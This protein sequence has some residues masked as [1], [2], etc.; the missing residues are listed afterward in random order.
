MLSFHLQ[1]FLDT[2]YETSPRQLTFNAKT[3]DEVAHWQARLRTALKAQLR[4][5]DRQLPGRI[6]A[7]ELY[8]IERD[9]YTETKLSLGGGETPILVYVL[10]PKTPPPYKA[11]MAFPGHGVGVELIL[12]LQSGSNLESDNDYAPGFA[13]AGYLV[14]AV[15]QQGFGER[16]TDQVA[17]TGAPT[18]C[19]HLAFEYLMHDRTLLGERVWDGMLAVQYI[20][21]RADVDPASIGCVGHSGGGT[22]TLFL[23]ALDERIGVSVI[24]CYFCSFRQSILKVKHC[25]CNYVPGLLKLAENGDFA[26]LIAPQPV[27]FI[28]GEKD[29][30]FDING[31]HD[32]FGV[33]KEVYSTLDAEDRCSLSVHPQGHAFKFDPAREWFDRWLK[34]LAETAG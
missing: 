5:T 16:V 25:A 30:I 15:E 14:C 11:I 7:T 12:G 9:G 8:S 3:P 24:S 4:I 6:N 32:Q 29:H 2:L 17:E 33:V 20:R 26:G 19:R 10:T 23:S 18:S 28:A 27:R 31:V 21:Q 13:R 34:P 1:S 22:T